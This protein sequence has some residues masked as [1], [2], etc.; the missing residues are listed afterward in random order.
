[1]PLYGYKVI[2]IYDDGP[3]EEFGIERFDHHP[4]SGET[5]QLHWLDG[6]VAHDAIVDH[7]DPD[8]LEVYVLKI[9]GTEL[10]TS[11]TTA[12]ERLR[13]VG[14]LV[15]STRDRLIREVGEQ[16]LVVAVV[17]STIDG[18]VIHSGL[19]RDILAGSDLKSQDLVKALHDTVD[20]FM[21]RLPSVRHLPA[22]EP[23]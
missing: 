18:T 3:S 16:G 1:M 21:A 11:E 20:A 22:G 10:S 19:I 17:V 2:E 6:R 14:L 7:V 5:F 23:S 9:E 12:T 4:V 13:D 15:A 8:R